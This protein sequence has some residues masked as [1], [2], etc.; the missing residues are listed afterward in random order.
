MFSH[1][2]LQE[3]VA[4]D[5]KSLDSLTTEYRI[6]IPALGIISLNLLQIAEI[7]KGM[8]LRFLRAAM[9]HMPT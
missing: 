8:K 9:L 2:G 4:W 6:R 5:P 1:M 3:V 7:F